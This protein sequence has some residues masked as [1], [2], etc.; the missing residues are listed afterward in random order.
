MERENRPEVLLQACTCS[1]I[2]TV[3]Q[4]QLLYGSLFP[5]PSMLTVAQ[6]SRLR[7]SLFPVS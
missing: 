7:K 1:S 6:N 3:A 4:S 2:F 5:L